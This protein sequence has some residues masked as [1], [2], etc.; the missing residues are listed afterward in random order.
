M[1][2]NTSTKTSNVDFRYESGHIKELQFDKGIESFTSRWLA[3]S[4]DLV[5]ILAFFGTTKM[6]FLE[7]ASW[8]LFLSFYFLFQ[9]LIPALFTD[10]ISFGRKI[11]RLDI[12]YPVDYSPI[13]KK[14]MYLLRE[15]VKLVSILLTGG[16]I[17]LIT[18][19]IIVEQGK[20]ALH[21][22]LTKIRVKRRPG[23]NEVKIADDF[24]GKFK[25]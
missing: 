7:D 15:L 11:M 8:A 4:L 2:M 22:M 12:H 17:L 6:L 16:L 21:E 18:P 1:L 25:L 14:Y 9:M 20:P 10:G 5:L 13:Q 23:K 19:L 3:F 24:D